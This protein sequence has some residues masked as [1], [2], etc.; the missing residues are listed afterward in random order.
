MKQKNYVCFVKRAIPL[1]R[2][3]LK[4]LEHY[5]QAV[6]FSQNRQVRPFKFFL[7]YVFVSLGIKVKFR[8]NSFVRSFVRD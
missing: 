3:F 7:E 4:D 1:K 6:A 5:S 8:R 2:P